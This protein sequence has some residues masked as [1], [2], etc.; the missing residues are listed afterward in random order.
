LCVCLHLCS[1][2]CAHAT[3]QHYGCCMLLLALLLLLL[4]IGSGLR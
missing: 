1:A 4:I 3:Q 2:S